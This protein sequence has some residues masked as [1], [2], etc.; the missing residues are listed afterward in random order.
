M[1]NKREIKQDAVTRPYMQIIEYLISIALYAAI[2][3]LELKNEDTSETGVHGFTLNIGFG[4]QPSCRLSFCLRFCM[5]A[6]VCVCVGGG[7]VGGGGVYVDWPAV[8]DLDVTVVL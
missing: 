6:S 3:S 2:Y 4:S 1:Q 5:R 8:S 7:G